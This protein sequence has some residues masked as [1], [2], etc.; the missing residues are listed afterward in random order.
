MHFTIPKAE[1]LKDKNGASFTGY[2]IHADGKLHCVVRYRQLSCLHDQLKRVFGARALPTFP[3]KKLLHLNSEEVEERRMLLERY[4]QLVSQDSKVF[5]SEVFNGFLVSAQLETQSAAPEQVTLDVYLLNNYR[6]SVTASSTLQTDDVLEKACQQINLPPRLTYYFGLFMMKKTEESY[7]I[8]RKL[9]DFEAPFISLRTAGHTPEHRIVLRKNYWDTSY[10]ADLLE[11]TVGRNLLYVQTVSEVEW[12]WMSADTDTRARLT[13]LQA[14][15]NKRE[16]VALAQQLPFYGYMQF[17]PCTCDFPVAGTRA[18]VSIGNKELNIRIPPGEGGARN[19]VREGSFKVTRM[20]CWRIS[21]VEPV[22]A[23]AGGAGPS[24]AAAGP[25]GPQL[26]LS[27]EY[28]MSRDQLQWVRLAS[29]QAVLMSV[30]LQALVEELLRRRKGLGI[31]RPGEKVHNVNFN[32][33]TRDG[34]LQHVNARSGAGDSEHV[35]C[36]SGISFRKLSNKLSQL[37]LVGRISLASNRTVENNA[38]DEIGDDEL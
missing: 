27:F 23:E 11:D 33:L 9:H 29:P 31:P 17:E 3:P 16:Y 25:T 28:L 1:E 24:S 19:T 6:I 26:E 12:G 5:S 15:G 34:S 20:R 22:P 37:N 7:T 13:M 35:D 10:D 21:S 38:F 18:R 14:K 32:Y 36:D 8:V 30:C 4:L 2:T